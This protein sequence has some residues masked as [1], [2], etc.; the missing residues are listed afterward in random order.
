MTAARRALVLGGGGVAGIAWETGVLAALEDAG[1]RLADADLVV[2]TSAGATVGAQLRSGT[3]PAVLLDRQRQGAVGELVSDADMAEVQRQ[4]ARAVL[5]V[6]ADPAEAR[7]RLA[8]VGLTV[9]DGQWAARRAVVAARLPS[10]RWPGRDLVLTAV[11]GESGELVVLD[12]TSGVDLVDAVAASC[13]V[14]GVWPAVPALGRRLVDGGIRS[15]TN[16]D[17]ATGCDVVVVL[18]PSAGVDALLTPEVV[19]ARRALRRSSR[20]LTVAADEASVAA[21]GPNSLDP[22]TRRPSADAGWAQGQRV[23]AE[24]G[25]VWEG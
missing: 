7:R 10:H 17:L 2:G 20:V 13:A 25:E 21:F 14:P 15:S 23:A 18:A 9:G 22:A 4:W 8:A 3:A 6:P 19:A 12:R 5:A 16:E 11:D 1:V 24:V